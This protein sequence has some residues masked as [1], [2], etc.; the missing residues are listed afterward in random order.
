MEKTANFGLNQWEKTDRI[1]MEDFNADNAKLEAALSKCGN[2]RM[3]TGTYTG[4][5]TAGSNAP[6]KL[7]FEELPEIV[8]VTSDAIQMMLMHGCSQA[9]VFTGNNVISIAVTWSGTTASWYHSHEAAYQM[10]VQN[11]EY[12]YFA[13]LRA[14]K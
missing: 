10:N 12:S 7:A 11:A 3:V 6:T 5:G 4:S 14:D 2:C 13:L 1:Q 8:F 9:F